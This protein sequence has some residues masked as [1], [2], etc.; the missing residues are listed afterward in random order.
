MNL[1]CKVKYHV[2]IIHQSVNQFKIHNW[3]VNKIE[4]GWMDVAGTDIIRSASGEI[5]E[6]NDFMSIL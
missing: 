5:I 1:R 2:D 6:D 3:A 4:I